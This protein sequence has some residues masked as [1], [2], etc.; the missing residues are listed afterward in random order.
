MP[1]T[2]LTS[3]APDPEP[4]LAC[5]SCDTAPNRPRTV[6]NRLFWGMRC[7]AHPN[8]SRHGLRERWSWHNGNPTTAIPL[9]KVLNISKHYHKITGKELVYKI[10]N[11]SLTATKWHSYRKSMPF[12]IL[13]KTKLAYNK[14]LP[15]SNPITHSRYAP[16]VFTIV[17]TKLYGQPRKWVTWERLV[18]QILEERDVRNIIHRE[19]QSLSVEKFSAKLMSAVGITNETFQDSI[20]LGTNLPDE[21]ANVE[22]ASVATVDT[23][24]RMLDWNSGHTEWGLL[25]SKRVPSQKF[26]DGTWFPHLGDIEV[27]SQ[28]NE[29]ISWVIWWPNTP[30]HTSFGMK[31][32]GCQWHRQVCS[33]KR[34]HEATSWERR[35][36]YRLSSHIGVATKREFSIKAQFQVL[37]CY[38]LSLMDLYHT[39][40]WS[41][42]LTSY[43]IRYYIYYMHT[44]FSYIHLYYIN[45]FV[46]KYHFVVFL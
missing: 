22:I 2:D 30:Y 5:R 6:H 36:D 45:Q 25:P 23:R 40:F 20:V 10:H 34:Q 19:P 11:Q 39:P 17:K 13:P 7:I 46:E 12:I 28:L 8:S 21:G 35:M 29:C 43:I 15:S 38:Y 26:H 41:I 1:G 9:S 4:S 44:I 42:H 3:G 27:L 16:N 14:T 18:T 37:Q 31:F 32:H 33:I 24:K